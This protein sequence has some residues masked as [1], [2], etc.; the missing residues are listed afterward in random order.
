M[1][2]ISKKR[3]GRENG[4]RKTVS[5]E[6]GAAYYTLSQIQIHHWPLI[7]CGAACRYTPALLPRLATLARITRLLLG[8]LGSPPCPRGIP[9]RC[10]DTCSEAVAGLEKLQRSKGG[11]RRAWC[12][13]SI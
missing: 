6:V 7:C 9:S 4:A 5:A 12:V 13:K 3:R 1:P 11:V 10:A 8:F 2:H